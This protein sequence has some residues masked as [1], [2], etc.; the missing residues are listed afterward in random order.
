MGE[1]ALDARLR[2]VPGV[3]PAAIAAGAAGRSLV[4]PAAQGGEA[5]WAGGRDVIAADSL[6]AL[7]NHFKGTQL[8]A[9]PAPAMPEPEAPLPTCATSRGRRPPGERWKSPPRAATTC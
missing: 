3:L 4:C 8:V 5:A 1:L 7:V 6:L 2:P 9:P